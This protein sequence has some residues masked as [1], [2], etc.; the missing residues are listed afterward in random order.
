MTTSTAQKARKTPAEIA[1]DHLDDLRTRR[2]DVLDD[3]KRTG[4]KTDWVYTEE[5]VS[6]EVDSVEDYLEAMKLIF[7]D[8][9]A[10]GVTT[11]PPALS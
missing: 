3:Y 10:E 7:T 4:G 11:P 5:S 8:L 9:R 1:R 6:L 2:R